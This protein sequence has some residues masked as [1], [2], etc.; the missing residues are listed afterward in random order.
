MRFQG[1]TVRSRDDPAQL[2]GNMADRR[3]RRVPD[4]VERSLAGSAQSALG[5]RLGIMS[6]RCVRQ[7]R[8]LLSSHT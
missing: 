7:E 5:R 1:L 2:I 4:L 3:M 8:T 6:R